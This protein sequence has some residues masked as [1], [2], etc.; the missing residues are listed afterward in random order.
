M[1]CELTCCSPRKVVTKSLILYQVA[2]SRCYR[3]FTEP[4]QNLRRISLQLCC[5]IYLITWHG[6][7]TLLQMIII[8]D[9]WLD[10]VCIK[11]HVQI[12]SKTC[13]NNQVHI[14]HQMQFHSMATR[15]ITY[16]SVYDSNCLKC[17]AQLKGWF[18]EKWVKIGFNF[19][20][21]FH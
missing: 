12:M 8:T 9:W 6:L 15:Q 13:S 2:L 1:P 7:S 16:V 17:L 14:K 3:S 21:T 18:V 10:H 4:S 5:P 20:T 19:K 11:H